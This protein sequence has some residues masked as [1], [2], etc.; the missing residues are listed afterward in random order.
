VIAAS[1][2][3]TKLWN[4]ARFILLQLRRNDFDH[5]APLTSLA[6]R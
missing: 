3:Q 6:D 1:R 5:A 2:F 4:I